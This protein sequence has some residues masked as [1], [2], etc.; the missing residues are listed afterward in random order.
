VNA[1]LILSELP[2]GLSRHQA[3]FLLH[4]SVAPSLQRLDYQALTGV[5]HTTAKRD[6]NLLIQTGLITRHGHGRSTR[7]SL[8]GV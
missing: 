6:L 5:S 4:L 2:K 7:Y 3:T 1:P 8:T